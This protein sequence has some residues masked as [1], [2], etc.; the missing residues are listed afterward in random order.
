M[1]QGYA[2]HAGGI[3]LPARVAGTIDV[4]FDGARIWSFNAVRDARLEDGSRVVRWPCQLLPHL[5]GTTEAALV[6][7]D[8]GRALYAAEVRFGDATQRVRLADEQGN[9]LALDKGGRLQRT[10]DHTGSD[11][12]REIVDAVARVLEQLRETCGLEAYLTYGCLLGAVRTGRVIGHDSDADVSY[13][14]RYTHPFDVIRESTRVRRRLRALGWTTVRMSGADFKIWVPLPDG[15][16]CG[17][18]VFASFY[19]GEHFHLMGSVR[20][21]LD[22]S[23]LLP[24]GTVT[25]EGRELPAPARPE[26][27]LELLYGP[28]WR[29]PDPAFHFDHD[30]ATV[31]RMDAWFREPRRR[32][33]FWRDFYR[34]PAAASVPTEPSPFARWVQEQVDSRDRILD[35]GCGNGRD[36]VWFAAQGHPV[37]ASDYAGSHRDAVRR[38]ARKHGVRVATPLL[39]LEDLRAVLTA[40]GRLAHRPGR[41]HVYARGLLDTLGANGRQNLWR[42]A[43]M[44]QRRSGT[45]FLEFRTPTG[46]HEPKAFGRHRR[47]Y[48]D[49]AAVVAEIERFGG[50]VLHQVI[51]RDLAP[52]GD[53][54]P[55]ICR[56]VVRWRR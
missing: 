21:R 54:N 24:L 22:R 27:L 17:V 39:N 14:S 23:A 29:V 9:P 51:G 35:L 1:G 4:L 25:L 33:R 38:L 30:R 26:Q 34:A 20:G 49:P 37:T 18:D 41:R 40:A 52:F 55:E 42:Y 53:E 50:T 36:A 32:H 11:S 12:R 10:F 43:S 13:L 28:G 46:R 48:P 44:V 6:A 8:D 47:T 7:H 16:R 3:T 15:R 19:V 45:T 31:H 2:V 56:L 5:R